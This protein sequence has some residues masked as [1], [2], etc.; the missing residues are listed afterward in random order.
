MEIIAT[1]V[2]NYYIIKDVESTYY[3]IVFSWSAVKYYPETQEI[4]STQF[5]REDKSGSYTFVRYIDAQAISDDGPISL[6]QLQRIKTLKELQK[7][8]RISK[9]FNTQCY[10]NFMKRERYHPSY[11]EHLRSRPKPVP[12]ERKKRS[13]YQTKRGPHLCLDSI[14]NKP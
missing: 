10:T 8:L 6:E 11:Y 3:K 12:K 2:S 7:L 1:H 5:L 14:I 4:I 9:V 13:D